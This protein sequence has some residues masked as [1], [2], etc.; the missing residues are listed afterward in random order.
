LKI[1]GEMKRGLVALL[2]AL[3]AAGG[4]AA[5]QSKPEPPATEAPGPPP[6]SLSALVDQVKERFPMIEG[7]VVEVQGKNLILDVGRP[8]G[9]RPGLR[10]EVYR[11]GREIK[12]PKTGE[13]LGRME[14]PRGTATVTAAQA[15]LSI[16]TFEGTDVAPSDRVRTGIGKTKLTLL[17]FKG[18]VKADLVEAVSHE[19]YEGLIRTGRFDVALGDQI[20]VWLTEQGVTPEAFLQGQRVSEAAAHFKVDNILAVSVRTVERKPFMDVRLFAQPRPEPA[21]SMA[22]FVPPSI[23][24]RPPGQFS[25]SDRARPAPERKPRSLL[26]RLLGGDL[27]A[28]A[29]SSGENSIPLKEVGRFA[30][31]VVAF[32][33]GVPSDRVPRMVISDGDKVYMYRVVDRALQAEWTYSGDRVGRV[34]SVHLVDIDGDG[35]P[36]VAVTRYDVD[37]GVLSLILTTKTGKPTVLV[38]NLHSFL[39][40][41]DEKGSGLKDVLWSQEYSP[42][43]LFAQR[44]VAKMALKDGELVDLGRVPVPESFRATGVAMSNIMGKDKR[45]L[46]YVDAYN[47]LRISAGPEELW[48]SSSLVGGGGYAPVQLVRYVVRDGISHFYSMEPTPLSVDLDGD[49][50]EEVVVPQNQIPGMLAVVFKGPAGVRFQQVNSGFEGLITG[51]GSIRGGEGEPPTLIAS[52]VRF[53]NVFKTSGETQ[54]IMTTAE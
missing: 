16:A 42:E 36:E 45:A 37:R 19:L 21:V 8:Q 28:G 5:A 52:V 46:V 41:V 29:Y 33:M 3:V 20:A 18:A 13:V 38:G 27:E 10:F 34:V 23:K 32:D 30:F 15:R 12:N 14:E 31:P 54:I 51:L 2:G 49:G 50:L 39:V 25:A 26:A 22:F 47:R 48:R 17:V 24:A 4:I 43:T 9:V 6:V 53:N 11:Q 40:A 1:A 44:Q 7:G 35:L